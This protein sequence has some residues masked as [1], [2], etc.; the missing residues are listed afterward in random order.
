MRGTEEKQ[1]VNKREKEKRKGGG[2]LHIGE[3]CQEHD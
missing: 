3:K 1:K 2:K